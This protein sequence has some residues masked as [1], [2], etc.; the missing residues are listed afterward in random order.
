MHYFWHN[1]IANKQNDDFDMVQ[2]L[3][4]YNEEFILY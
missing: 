3:F 2:L 1:G 4:G